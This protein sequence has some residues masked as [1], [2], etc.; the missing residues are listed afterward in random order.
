MAYHGPVGIDMLKTADGRIHPCIE[1]NL[2]MNMG[3]LALLLHERYGSDATVALTPER[4]HGFRA[5]VDEGKLMIQF[6][7]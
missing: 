2:R 4:E 3:I 5:L 6:H 7:P 1:I